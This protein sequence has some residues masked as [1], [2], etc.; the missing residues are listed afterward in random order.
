[1]VN[2]RCFVLALWIDHRTRKCSS[3]IGLYSRSHSIASDR[4]WSLAQTL[5]TMPNSDRKIKKK[6]RKEKDEKEGEKFWTQIWRK[7]TEILHAIMNNQKII[8]YILLEQLARNLKISL[9]LLARLSVFPVFLET[10]TYFPGAVS[11][12][13]IFLGTKFWKLQ[14]IIQL[15]RAY[16]GALNNCYETSQRG[17]GRGNG[18]FSIWPERVFFAKQFKVS[19]F[20]LLKEEPTLTI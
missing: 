9:A 19:R 6:E 3:E 13:I 2:L 4:K 20:S 1:M 8:I 7:L 14:K 10:Q 16:V 15:G 12:Q 17:R 11:S 5:S 18:H